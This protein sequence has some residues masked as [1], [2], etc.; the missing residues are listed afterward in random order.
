MP[1]QDLGEKQMAGAVEGKEPW[2]WRK[3]KEWNAQIY[4]QEH[5]SKATSERMSGTEFCEC[6]QPAGLKDWS[7]GSPWACLL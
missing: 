2:S 5:F 7:L 6:F 4:A 3:L 1:R